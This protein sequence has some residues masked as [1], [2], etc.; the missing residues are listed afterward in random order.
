MRT[1]SYY[2]QKLGAL[3]IEK[4]KGTVSSI[5]LGTV[6]RNPPVGASWTLLFT[7]TCELTD[8][9]MVRE[10]DRIL[11]MARRQYDGTFETLS[12]ID[13]AVSAAT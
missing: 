13:R 9:T 7:P 11:M 6:N 12:H 5:K 3:V 1:T 2:G 8:A 4:R 10:I